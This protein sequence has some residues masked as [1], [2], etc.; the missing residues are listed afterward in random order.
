M[1]LERYPPD[2]R[3]EGGVGD[4]LLVVRQ[5]GRLEDEH[6]VGARERQKNGGFGDVVDDAGEA[7]VEPTEHGEDEPRPSM[8]LSTAQSSAAFNLML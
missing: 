6:V 4:V 2:G 7:W 8:G 1:V 5:L 3:E